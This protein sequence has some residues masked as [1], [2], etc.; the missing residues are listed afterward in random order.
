M[1]ALWKQGE[2]MSRLMAD[3]WDI[4]DTNG[5]NGLARLNE[6]SLVKG[7]LITYICL[8]VLKGKPPRIKGMCSFIK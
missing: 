7:G 8:S 6:S 1:H 2:W 3:V 4:W 5:R